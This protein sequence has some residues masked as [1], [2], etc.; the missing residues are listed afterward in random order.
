MSFY[1][2]VEKAFAMEQ[3][4][5]RIVPLHIG[6]TNLPT[7]ASAIRAATE[8]LSNKRSLYG[9]GAGL[10]QLRE[11]IARRE[12]CAVENVVVGPGSKHLL[13]GLLSVLGKPGMR[14]A[15]PAPGWPAY[16]LMARQLRLEPVSLPTSL[17][18]GWLFDPEAARGCG[19]FML[20]NPQ[21]PTSTVYPAE[22]VERTLAIAREAGGQVIL[23]EAYKGLAFEPMPRIDGAL[24]VRSFSKEFSMEGW[25]LGYAVAPA[26]V[27]AALTGFNQITATC[28]AD[29]VQLAGISC[30]EEEE[31]ILGAVRATW[32][33][34]SLAGQ[35][36]LRAAGFQFAAPQGGMY[37]FA[38]HPKLRDADKLGERLL[39][40]GV[41]IAPGSGF[42]DYPRFV[43]LCLNQEP[44]VLE[45]AI[46]QLAEAIDELA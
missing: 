9:P 8:F 26:P 40:R 2:I 34:R 45:Q 21:N 32:K 13:F 11:R 36:A 22:L 5:K 31:Q 30:L 17:E 43:R 38:T 25:R 29:F 18:S 14:I 23:D 12:G 7:P 19:L 44:A 4:G 27:A 15:I 41:A 28:V 10:R 16:A 1:A 39:E 46:R 42:G 20:C 6:D 24:R 3:A 33:R 35:A 37:V